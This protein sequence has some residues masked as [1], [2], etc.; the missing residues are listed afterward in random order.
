MTHAE[1][2]AARIAEVVNLHIAGRKIPPEALSDLDASIDHLRNHAD[3]LRGELAYATQALRRGEA[4][5]K[6][7][8]PVPREPESQIVSVDYT[9]G[10]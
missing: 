5:R 8:V 4:I 10:P 7:I 3:V 1:S 2:L 6:V 9:A